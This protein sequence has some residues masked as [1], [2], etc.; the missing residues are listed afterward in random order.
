MHSHGITHRDLKPENILLTTQKEDTC[1]MKLADFGLS[2]MLNDGEAVM[3][4]ICGTWAYCAPEIIENK[5]YTTAV[6]NWT[7]GILMY[8]MV[9]GY[10]PFDIYGEKPQAQLLRDIRDVNYNFDDEVW[11]YVSEP[12]KEIIRRL[13]TYDPQQRMT[14]EEFRN[15][16]WMKSGG[17][18]AGFE[19][20]DEAKIALEQ[21][22]KKNMK[23]FNTNRVNWQV[24]MG[25][26]KAAGTF[27]KKLRSMRSMHTGSPAS[28]LR[29][30][31]ALGEEGEK[32]KSV[33]AKENAEE[34]KMDMAKERSELA[35]G[36]VVKEESPSGA[37]YESNSIH[38]GSTEIHGASKNPQAKL[39]S[40]AEKNNG[41]PAVSSIETGPAETSKSASALNERSE[42]DVAAP[43]GQVIEPS[44]PHTEAAKIR[45]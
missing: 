25:T 44:E 35:S 42:G 24:T 21:A 16:R 19:M 38:G 28:N 15:S 31:S 9:S 34:Q 32:V 5:P 29:W 12:A 22:A 37:A 26:L 4:T 6:D 14:L 33:V 11:E 36:A 43:P 1:D 2:K 13:M 7:L 39:A 8:I 3:E 27:K 20:T 23:E 10:H 41:A 18:A 30:S 17:K 40:A 45:E